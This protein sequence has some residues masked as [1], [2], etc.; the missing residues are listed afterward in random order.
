MDMAQFMPLTG[1]KSQPLEQGDK[2]SSIPTTTPLL[3]KDV[4]H[5]NP[6]QSPVR[7]SAAA[8]AD[9]E[10]DGNVDASVGVVSGV[11]NAWSTVSAQ[12]RLAGP[13]ALLGHRKT[14]N[15]SNN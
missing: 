6:P 4:P 10:A 12:V 7:P 3:L 2:L 11:E 15:N 13:L 5:N 14:D 9:A 1:T 8:D